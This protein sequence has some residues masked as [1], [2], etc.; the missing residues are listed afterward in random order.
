MPKSDFVP[1]LSKQRYI[2]K[3]Q[4]QPVHSFHTFY[5]FLKHEESMI[6]N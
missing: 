4:T 3:L 2:E 5:E 6:E 1:E